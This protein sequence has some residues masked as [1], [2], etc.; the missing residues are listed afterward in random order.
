MTLLSLRSCLF[1]SEAVERGSQINYSSS[2]KIGIAFHAPTVQQAVGPEVAALEPAARL[3]LHPLPA[4]AP[5]S[6]R[7]TERACSTQQLLKSAVPPSTSMH[8]NVYGAE[9][10]G[11][12]G[13]AQSVRV[14]VPPEHGA[15]GTEAAEGDGATTRSVMAVGARR[16][17]ATCRV[18]T[19]GT[20]APGCR[21]RT[22]GARPRCSGRGRARP[23]GVRRW[24]DG[25][26]GGMAQRAVHRGRHGM[27]HV[28]QAQGTAV[29][30]HR[31]RARGMRFGG[32]AR[33]GCSAGGVAARSAKMA[34]RARGGMAM[35]EVVVG[36][37]CSPCS[38]CSYRVAYRAASESTVENTCLCADWVPV[39]DVLREVR[40]RG[41]YLMVHAFQKMIG[42]SDCENGAGEERS[43]GE[44]SSRGNAGWAGARG[45]QQMRAHGHGQDGAGDVEGSMLE[46]GCMEDG[47]SPLRP[48]PAAS[49]PRAM[50]A[51]PATDSGKDKRVAWRCRSGTRGWS[52]MWKWA[53]DGHAWR[54]M[55]ASVADTERE[56]GRCGRREGA[57]NPIGKVP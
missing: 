54:R 17:V 34:G 57:G 43:G 28:N 50:H 51:E 18:L 38:P 2:V 10:G 44:M 55:R 5:P 9:G 25:A 36:S 20:T 33:R 7:N 14:T 1:P 31:A 46:G 52:R 19:K 35:H 39:D 22:C 3:G 16:D 40:Q 30:G 41:G 29:P 27:Q 47:N 37:T 6:L 48:F 45:C 23:Q 24:W 12:D 32:G 49:L 4:S 42:R 21:V 53:R 8:P 56:G 11:K 15:W 26:H 13:G